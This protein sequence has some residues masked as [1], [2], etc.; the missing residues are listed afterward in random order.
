MNIK[1]IF[2]KTYQITFREE[3]GLLYG[4]DFYRGFIWEVLNSAVETAKKKS[5]NGQGKWMVWE[6]KKIS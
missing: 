1:S 5:E 4:V 6:I 2:W 3:K